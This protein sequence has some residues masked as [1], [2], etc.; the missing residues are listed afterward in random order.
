VQEGS[1]ELTLGS[2]TY[3][4]AADDCLA[5]QLNA[6]TTFY[7]RTDRPA[8]YIVVIATDRLRTARK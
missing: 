5:M 3:H 2:I 6:P 7:N 8:R 4:L 1:I